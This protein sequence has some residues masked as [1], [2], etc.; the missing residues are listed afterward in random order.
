MRSSPHGP[1]LSQPAAWH[2]GVIV[3]KEL[4]KGLGDDDRD[5]MLPNGDKQGSIALEGPSA[6]SR[7]V[8]GFDTTD[9]NPGGANPVTKLNRSSES[10]LDAHKDSHSKDG[11]EKKVTPRKR[12]LQTLEDEVSVLRLELG[13]IKDDAARQQRE[14]EHL[15]CLWRRT[16]R[17]LTALSKSAIRRRKSLRQIYKSARPT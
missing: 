12:V 13:A 9:F 4:M 15:R 16:S 8:M 14:N 6:A 3:G 17:R 7:G 5:W 10:A 11:P 2:D 1:L